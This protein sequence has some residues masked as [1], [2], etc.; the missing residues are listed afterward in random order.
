MY[1]AVGRLNG[2]SFGRASDE[3]TRHNS[4]YDQNNNIMGT[5]NEENENLFS[6]YPPHKQDRLAATM[7]NFY[8]SGGG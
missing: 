6:G 7:T 4:E 1:G 5:N 3:G 2:R 8:T